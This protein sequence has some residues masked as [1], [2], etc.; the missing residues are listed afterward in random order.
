MIRII[1]YIF[2]IILWN[3]TLYSSTLPINYENHCQNTSKCSQ[4]NNNTLDFSTRLSRK[5]LIHS[6]TE[7]N[8][9][10]YDIN[11]N[12]ST[13]PD[14][15]IHD[16]HNSHAK[17][18][19]KKPK[20]DNIPHA[21]TIAPRFTPFFDNIENKTRKNHSKLKEEDVAWIVQELKL[22]KVMNWM[23]EDTSLINE[24]FE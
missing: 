21:V 5:T 9:S 3:Q 14:E 18:Q 15:T 12:D 6:T 24:D 23:L 17:K 2:M 10:K 11:T 1:A 4:I 7:V 19:E 22:P 13:F 16:E 8:P 20:K